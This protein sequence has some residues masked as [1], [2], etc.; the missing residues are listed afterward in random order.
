MPLFAWRLRQIC[1]VTTIAQNSAAKT[2]RSIKIAKRPGSTAEFIIE[3][4]LTTV[5]TET[6]V[7]SKSIEALQEAVQQKG[8]QV[9]L[10]EPLFSDALGDQGTP[11]ATLI[12]AFNYNTTQILNSLK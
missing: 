8:G 5:F 9:K 12:G 11:E 2:S 7:N 6:S 3:R 4:E 10:G 1:A